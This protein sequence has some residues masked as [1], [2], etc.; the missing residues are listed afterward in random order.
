M[1]G[2]YLNPIQSAKITT[3]KSFNFKYGQIEVSA[4]LPKGSWLRP[5]I[6]LL[7]LRNVYGNWPASG[8][9]VLME[10]RGNLNYPHS[11]GGGVD[12]FS[13]S[14]HWGIDETQNR[15]ES[16]H[17]VYHHPVQLSQEFHK[18]GL[19]WTKDRIYTYIDEE[20]NV[21]L[22]VDFSQ[23]LFEKGEF[24]S[25]FKNPWKNSNKNAPFDQEF[26]L[27]LNLAVGGNSGYFKDG[28]GNKPWTNSNN[29]S[30]NQF[31][32]AKDKWYPSW[33]L[34]NN[35]LDFLIDYIKVWSLD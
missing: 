27:A 26:Y 34:N 25:N 18:Y 4:R 29:N 30:V 14:L 32:D 16:T 11:A 22:D 33:Y 35:R 23:N 3:L 31:Y 24:R 8:E 9:I 21:V 19:I 13:S 6:R 5:Q 20:D 17:E 12:S 15:Y 28:V 2:R 1:Y 10:S 7:P